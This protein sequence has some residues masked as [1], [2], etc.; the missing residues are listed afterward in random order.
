MKLDPEV[1]EYLKEITSST[2]H[3]VDLGVEGSRK[4]SKEMEEEYAWDP[5]VEVSVKDLRIRVKGGTIPLRIYRPKGVDVRSLPILI[6][7]HGGG[8]VLGY[9]DSLDADSVCKYLSS[10]ASC[11]VVSV[12]YRLS[13]ESKFPGPVEDCYAAL[14]WTAEHAPTFGGD[15][16]RI[17]V[18]GD[19]AGGNLAA[20]VCLMTRDKG[21]PKVIFQAPVYPITD[22]D[23]KTESYQLFGKGYGLDTEDMVWFAEQ[24]LSRKEDASNP[25]ASPMRAKDLS[26][27]PP[28]FVMTAGL[29]PLRDEGEAYG[30]KLRAAGVPGKIRRIE[31]MPHGFI[32]LPFGEEPREELATE[33]RRAFAR[34]PDGRL[35]KAGR[36]PR[37]SYH[38]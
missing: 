28:A 11:V 21:G 33:L 37:K 26:G 30:R 3:L 8:W 31:G 9:V 20:V 14:K 16:S 23:V 19:S 13:P 17:A 34:A 15:A 24:Y 38:D 18:A 7:L 35:T 22:F 32:T 5:Q 27:L 36:R 25:Y 6:W 12:G 1:A 4:L 29:D 10:G 2:Q